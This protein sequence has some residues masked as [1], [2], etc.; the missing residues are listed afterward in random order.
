MDERIKG[1]FRKIY[2]ELFQIILVVCCL[3]VVIKTTFLGMTAGECIPEF[4]IMISSPVYLAIR[5][6]MLGISQVSSYPDKNDKTKRT[7]LLAGLFGFLLVFVA[8]SAKR[9][10]TPG[11]TSNI[12]CFPSHNKAGPSFTTA[13]SLFATFIQQTGYYTDSHKIHP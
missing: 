8:Q 1:E 9:W 6:R 3:S 10:E 4:P 5:S 12:F 2:S 11:M 13:P 7:A